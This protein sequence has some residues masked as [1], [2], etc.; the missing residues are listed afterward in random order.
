LYFNKFIGFHQMKMLLSA[1]AVSM[2]FVGAANAQTTDSNAVA[3]N[4]T[5]VIAVAQGATT[6][7]NTTSNVNSSGHLYTTPAVPGGTYFGGANPCLVGVGAGGAGGPIGLSL[8]FSHNDEGCT[9]RSDAAA[10]HALG[11]DNV[12]VARMNQD[13]D[14]LKA[15]KAAMGSAPVA[16][17]PV[18]EV[19]PAVAPVAAP[20]ATPA[21]VR[22]NVPA[23]C[24]T[25]VVSDKLHAE[26]I[27][28]MCQ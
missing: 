28:Y 7:A 21:V 23:W 27:K 1:L 26:Y 15:W 6:P 10:W 17:A 18:A 5:Q 16:P 11:Y 22:K 24:A 2:L 8:S 9:R 12:A 25:A 4:R 14:N 3:A 19:T 20:V 13:D